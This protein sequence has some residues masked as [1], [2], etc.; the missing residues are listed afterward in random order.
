MPFYPNSSLLT[1]NN[2]RN[3]NY[4]T[5]LI[6]YECLFSYKL[7]GVQQAP[8]RISH[9]YSFSQIEAQATPA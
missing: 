7:L 8:S 3:I 1:G 4:M 6:L 5:V 9:Q 2:A